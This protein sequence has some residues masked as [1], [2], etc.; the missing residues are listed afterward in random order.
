MIAVVKAFVDPYL[1]RSS[2]QNKSRPILLSSPNL[3]AGSSWERF[4]ANFLTAC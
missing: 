3:D 2:L 4:D 1:K